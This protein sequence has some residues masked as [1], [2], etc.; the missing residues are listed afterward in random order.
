MNGLSEDVAEDYR[1]VGGEAHHRWTGDDAAY[2]T[3]HGRLRD[4]R[5]RAEDMTCVE[6]GRQAADW[7][8]NHTSGVEMYDSRGCVYSPDLT[9]YV[10]MC[11]SCHK[12]YDMTVAR[13]G[14]H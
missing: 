6:C 5:G 13:V 11:K 3:V 7:A 9:A 2:G 1:T 4:E 10:P 12:K 8:Y 14:A